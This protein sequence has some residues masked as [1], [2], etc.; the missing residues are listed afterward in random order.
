MKP[1]TYNWYLAKKEQQW[2]CRPSCHGYGG[3]QCW[4]LSCF[5]LGWENLRLTDADRSEGLL[6]LLA[7]SSGLSQDFLPQW[8]CPT[9]LLTWVT[10]D[11]ANVTRGT[12]FV[13]SGVI[14]FWFE[15]ICAPSS[16]FIG[17]F[18]SRVS[19]FGFGNLVSC[20]KTNY[21][22]LPSVQESKPQRF[23]SV[24]VCVWVPPTQTL[25]YFPRE[26]LIA[27]FSNSPLFSL[28]SFCFWLLQDWS[29]YI[30]LFVPT[31]FFV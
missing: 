5:S 20:C 17:Q 21:C 4:H 11:L 9:P 23:V 13:T 1:I 31:L 18:C 27:G 25:L 8:E 19:S 29:C 6:S 7:Q 28:S 26:L 2:G 14:V 3:L 30:M 12:N 16:S 24:C 10:E 22:F 15:T